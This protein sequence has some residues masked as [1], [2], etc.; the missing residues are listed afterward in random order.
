MYAYTALIFGSCCKYYNQTFFGSLAP[1]DLLLDTSSESVHKSVHTLIILH[2][3]LK[4]CVKC[5]KLYATGTSSRFPPPPFFFPAPSHFL[6]TF[7]M[8]MLLNCYANVA[9]WF[10]NS[11]YIK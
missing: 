4:K 11:G 8:K 1:I 10:Q 9:L 2:I 7:L 5:V 3:A 6:E